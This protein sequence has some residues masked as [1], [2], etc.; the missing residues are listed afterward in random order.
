M[1]HSLRLRLTVACLAL[2]A[3]G[4]IGVGVVTYGVVQSYLVHRVDQQLS[5]RAAAA[6]HS[7]FSFPGDGGPP[8]DYLNNPGPRFL[9]NTLIFG[10][11]DKSGKVLGTTN[12]VS[13]NDLPPSLPGSAK[14]PSLTG[15]RSFDT[16]IASASYRALAVPYQSTYGTVTLV[17]AMPLHEVNST[18]DE[19]L[20]AELILGAIAVIAVG[21]AVWW[22]V[23]RGLRPLERMADTATAIAGG[24]L[25]RRVEEDG[26]SEIGQLG[27]AFNGMLTQIEGEIAERRASEERLRRFAA[28][29]SHELRTP[30]T[31]IRGYAEL[32]RRGA[33]ERPQ[34]LALTMRRIES[35]A[36]RMTSL[37]DDLLLL[38]RLDRKRPLERNRVDIS[39]LVHDVVAGER[40]VHPDRE[41][42]VD[43]DD[44]RV[45]GDEARLRQVLLNL[46]ANAAS[47]TPA[48]TPI[49]LTAHIIDAE[50]V[51][52][53]ADHGEGLTKEDAEHVFER[54]FRVDS[55]RGREDGGGSGLGLAIVAAIVDAHGGR[56]EV[57]STPGQG[58]RFRVRLPASGEARVREPVEV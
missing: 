58:A 34:D 31:S 30:L 14:D 3:V 25:S 36:T 45:L 8:P 23:R 19:I 2:L 32:F 17:F 16:T 15:Q 42:R 43:V 11:V 44:M 6:L 21:I 54:F 12:G 28:D 56:V 26:T 22:L 38:A 41:Y 52:E 1:R 9:R 27:V 33:S 7:R 53:V 4:L 39:R 57:E 5:D 49:E 55:A 13:L 37:V 29:A 51:I 20:L 47:H 46:L 35:E 24:D 10:V 18:L 40:I 50:A 48:A